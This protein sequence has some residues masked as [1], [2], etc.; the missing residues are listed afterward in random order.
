[1]EAPQF[2]L[3]KRRQN[4][5]MAKS[6]LYLTIS[7]VTTF[8]ALAATPTVRREPN[9]SHEFMCVPPSPLVADN[10]DEL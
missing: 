3:L 9:A 8:G 1:V 10:L 7:E 4:N 5:F 2:I 6:T